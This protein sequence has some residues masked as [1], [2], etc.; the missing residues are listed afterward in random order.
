MTPDDRDRFETGGQPRLPGCARNRAPLEAPWHPFPCSSCLLGIGTVAGFH[1]WGLAGWP[2]PSLPLLA[3]L[4]WRGGVVAASS[5]RF[6]FA[7]HLDGCLADIEK[8]AAAFLHQGARA[9]V[10]ALG[11]FANGLHFLKQFV[12]PSVGKA[13]HDGI[14]LGHGAVEAR[15]GIVGLAYDAVD[16][17]ALARQTRGIGF[18]IQRSE[19]HT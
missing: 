15:E 3:R 14:D 9:L 6:E 1:A 11:Q 10:E 17:I 16:R 5:L 18:K 13:G 12:G 19:E 7:G 2:R 8:R 4:S